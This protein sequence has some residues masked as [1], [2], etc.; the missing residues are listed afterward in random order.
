MYGC[1]AGCCGP[2]CGCFC[3]CCRWICEAF[4][5]NLCSFCFIAGKEKK[6]KAKADKKAA[7]AK[8]QAV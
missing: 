8:L 4:C 6:K 2:L 5:G 7:E 1:A 3:S